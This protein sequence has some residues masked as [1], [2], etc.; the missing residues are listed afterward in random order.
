MA[1]FS[2]LHRLFAGC[3][4]M[5]SLAA[6]GAAQTEDNSRAVRIIEEPPATTSPPGGQPPSLQPVRPQPPSLQAPALQP[7]VPLAAPAPIVPRRPDAGQAALAPLPPPDLG[8]VQAS[9]RTK[10]SAGVVV[11]VLPRTK[12]RV[13]EKIAL[14]VA[15]K[16]R[17]YLVLVDVDA[18]GKLTQIYPNRR[19]LLLA[20]ESKDTANLIT[21]GQPVT[22][23]E[24]GNPYAGFELVAS[25]PAGVA[26]IVAILSDRPVQ[27]LDLPEIPPSLIGRGGAIGYLTD[28]TRNLRIAQAGPSGRLEKAIWSFD[29]K[30]YEIR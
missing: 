4:V 19:S 21:P 5:V 7:S 2:V 12:L 1:R 30:L 10:N 29:A 28:W 20:Q 26:M 8:A 15:T 11:D 17:G 24:L 23:P 14:R 13:G 25:P 3:L 6:P 18:T 27:M 16:K 22:I 9:L